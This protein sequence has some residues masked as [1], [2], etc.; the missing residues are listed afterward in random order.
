MDASQ[1]EAILPCLD[2]F[3][4]QHIARWKDTP[5]LS[6]F[7]DPR[8]QSFYRAFAGAAA[9]A[10]W[11]GFTRLRWEN[12]DIA[13]HYGFCYAGT[14]LWY[15]PSFAIE[16]AKR[17]PGEVLL[18]HLINAAVNERAHTFDFGMGEEAFK[19]RFATHV[20]Y[21]RNFGLYPR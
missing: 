1:A 4:Q 10:G 8:Q 14:F 7:L 5:Y 18:R 20:R 3:F 6:L 17:S 15:K 19:S 9:S 2:G 13:Y 21:I 12:Q 11:L 16:L